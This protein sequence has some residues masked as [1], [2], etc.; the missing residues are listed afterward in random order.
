MSSL[1]DVLDG[2]Q[3]ILYS[4]KASIIKVLSGPNC[5]NEYLVPI[6]LQQQM[7]NKSLPLSIPF[8]FVV[9]D[10]SVR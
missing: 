5:D 10:G 4:K 2:K 3:C 7:H 8:I 1:I 9:K 6:I